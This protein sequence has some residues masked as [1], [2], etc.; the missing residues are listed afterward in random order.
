MTALLLWAALPAFAD[1]PPQL[2]FG[3]DFAAGYFI[4]SLR[5]DWPEPGVGGAWVARYDAFIQPATTR[6]P[7]LGASLWGGATLAPTQDAREED[8]VVPIS[9]SS[10]GVLSVLRF[11]PSAPVSGGFGFGFGRVDLDDYYGGAQALPALTFEGILRKRAREPAFV[12]L[13]GRVSW[14]QSRSPVDAGLEDWWLVQ[15]GLMIGGHIH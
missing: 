5:G 4:G 2:A 9:A 13:V 6:G 1:E 8:A 15:G 10:M 3:A 12:D 11:D 14:A 7:R